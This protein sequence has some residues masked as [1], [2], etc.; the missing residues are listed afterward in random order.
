MIRRAFWLSVGAAAGIAGYRRASAVGRA[1]Q[2]R[3][4]G[5]AQLGTGQP[6]QRQPAQTTQA[7][8]APG[9][10]WPPRAVESGSAAAQPR[11][12]EGLS[13]ASPATRRPAQPATWSAT[14]TAWRTSRAAWKVQKSAVARVRSAGRFARDVREGMDVYMSRQDD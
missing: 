10:F 13:P 9:P 7:Q 6:A 8:S 5:A 4:N 11:F 12:T 2:V 1:V 14:R 3:V